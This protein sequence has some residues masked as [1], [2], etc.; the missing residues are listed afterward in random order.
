[1]PSPSR[2]RFGSLAEFEPGRVQP[3]ADDV[4]HYAFSN[5]FDVAS[6]SL[7]HERVVIAQNQQYVLEAVRAEGTSPWFACAH[8]EFAL[9]M[10]GAVEVH[11]LQLAP[12]CRPGPGTEGAVRLEG[13]PEGT[14]MGWMKLAR[15][16]QGLLPAHSAYQFVARH[17]AVLVIQSCK[18]AVSVEKWAEIC[19]LQ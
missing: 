2:T 13:P 1:M 9:V 7:P 16:H 18:G 4:R 15:G 19:Q 3:I 8:D 5:C 14:R 17:P 11:L 12:H 10:D 6:R